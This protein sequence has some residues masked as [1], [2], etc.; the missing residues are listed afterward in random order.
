MLQHCQAHCICPE[1]GRFV[2]QLP[3]ESWGD[4]STVLVISSDAS[5]DN[6]LNQCAND[7][8]YGSLGLDLVMPVMFHH[9]GARD[10]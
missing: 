6:D 5:G 2:F 7:Q 1:D 8:Q 4:L 10:L 9:F 3:S